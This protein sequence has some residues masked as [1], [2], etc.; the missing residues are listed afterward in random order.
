VQHEAYLYQ[1]EAGFVDAARSFVDEGTA[2]GEAVLV[3]TSAAQIEALRSAV[4]SPED[5]RFADMAALGRNPTRIISVWRKFVRD[6]VAAGRGFRG[7]GEPVWADRA[8]AELVE[9][10]RHEVLLNLAFADGPPWRL[11]CPYNVSALP[12]AVI[13]EALASHPIV[14]AAGQRWANGRY[15]P[16]LDRLDPALP[17]PPP[18]AV[19]LAFTDH[20]LAQLREVVASHAAMTTLDADRI[21]ELVL[22]VHEVAVNSIQH[23]GGSRVL[24]VWLES[25]GV[26]C[27]VSDDGWVP[28]P[29][30]GRE[31]P[32]PGSRRGRGLWLAN[33]WCDLVQWR[34]SLAGTQVRMH[35][36]PPLHGDGSSESALPER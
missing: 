27:D 1:C 20:D 7:I 14:G 10:Q 31:T 6:C 2:A 28:D 25:G 26:V 12:A 30:A 11:M 8:A 17:P 5:V 4:A 19:E 23:G 35:M 16:G 34:S 32:P 24:R 15:Q 33:E 3:A 36:A 21:A 13:D 9:C 18:E 22:V 29:L